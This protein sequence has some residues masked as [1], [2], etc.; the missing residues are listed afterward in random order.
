MNMNIELAIFKMLLIPI[1][2]LSKN[3]KSIFKKIKTFLRKK[4]LQFIALVE[5]GVRKPDRL[6]KNMELILIS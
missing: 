2:Q 5:L 1:F 6:C 3:S 4:K